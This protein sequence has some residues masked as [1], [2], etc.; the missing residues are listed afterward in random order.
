MKADAFVTEFVSMKYRTNL[1]HTFQ[2]CIKLH[3]PFQLPLPSIVVFLMLLMPL[4]NYIDD[5][6]VAMVT[7]AV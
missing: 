7:T 2:V 1:R 3:F 4:V 5:D 6:D